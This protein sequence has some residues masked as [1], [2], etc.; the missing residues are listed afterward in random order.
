M[1]VHH[2]PSPNVSAHNTLANAIA[3]PLRLRSRRRA[4]GSSEVFS[5]V[6]VRDR[7]ARPPLAGA[8][9]IPRRTRQTLPAIAIRTNANASPGHVHRSITQKFKALQKTCMTRISGSGPASGSGAHGSGGT[10]ARMAGLRGASGTHGATCPLCRHFGHA[11][12]CGPSQVG[13]PKALD[14]TEHHRP[15]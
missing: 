10:R 6:G 2:S 3:S 5:K 15:F 14:V 9:R 8:A 4:R 7:L 13:Y 12:H 1:H 11:V